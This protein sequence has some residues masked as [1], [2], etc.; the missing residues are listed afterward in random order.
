MNKIEE[1]KKRVKNLQLRN[2]NCIMDD[3]LF[4]NLDIPEEIELC[5]ETGIVVINNKGYRTTAKAFN[6]NDYKAISVY[7][8]EELNKEHKVWIRRIF[9][10]SV[11]NEYTMMESLSVNKLILQP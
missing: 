7:L 3:T 10:H 8:K 11:G 5:D 2:P 1:L 9:T 4:N 6:K